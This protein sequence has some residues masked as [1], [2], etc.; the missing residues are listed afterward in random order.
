MALKPGGII[1][2]RLASFG[3]ETCFFHPMRSK[4]EKTDVVS[5]CKWTGVGWLRFGM[6]WLTSL[7]NLDFICTSGIVPNRYSVHSF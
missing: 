2:H 6:G 7:H 1:W 3:I 4:A 5:V